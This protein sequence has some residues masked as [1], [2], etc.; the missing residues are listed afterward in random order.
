MR[1]NALLMLAA[2]LVL[3]VPAT[4]AAG[5]MFSNPT[6]RNLATSQGSQDKKSR[7]SGPETAVDAAKNILKAHAT[8]AQVKSVQKSKDVDIVEISELEKDAS[9]SAADYLASAIRWNQ[10]QNFEEVRA[11]MRLNGAVSTK[12]RARD[13]TADNVMA[14]AMGGSETLTLYVRRPS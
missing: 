9:K 5:G 4:A 8:A 10:R 6:T 13:L 1:R 12:L 7:K 14:A 2:G 3:A 11:A